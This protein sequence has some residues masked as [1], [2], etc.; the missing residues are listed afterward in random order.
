MTDQA[1]PSQP[2]PEVSPRLRLLGALLLAGYLGLIGW[3][4]LRPLAVGWT[5]PA[6]LTP[7][8]SVRDAFTVGGTTGALQLASGL[9]PLAP[10]GI[11]LPLAGGR[12]RAAWL[13]SLLRTAGGSAL[14]ATALEILKG[15][16]PG[17]V[18]NVDNIVLG[19]LGVTACHLAV[20]PAVRAR[21]AGRSR[22]RPERGT[23]GFE[24]HTPLGG[25]GAQRR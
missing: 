16:A 1:N 22:R 7:F 5:Y 24:L 9:L 17:H 8:A 15:W 20:V 18:L 12:V 11:L 2:A 10:L 25:L 3:L 21:L 19:V 14:I 23:R 13:P 4:I 6:N